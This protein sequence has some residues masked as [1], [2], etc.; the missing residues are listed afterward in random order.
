MK[1]PPTADRSAGLMELAGVHRATRRVTGLAMGFSVVTGLLGLTA[2]LYM[3]QVYD[4]VLA[5]RSVET[6]VALSLVMAFLFLILGILD[7]ARSRIMARV[8][9]RLQAA[10]DARVLAA[11][12]RR[13]ALAP[14]DMPALAA[15][16]DLDALSRFWASPVLLAL[17]D[18][19]WTPVFLVLIMLFHPLLGLLALAGGVILVLMAWAC[20]ST[21]T[22]PLKA[23][24][25][26]LLAADRQ[27]DTL[28]AE[29]EVVRAMGMGPAAIARWSAHRSR[30][31]ED[32]LAASDAAGTYA[33]ASRTFRLF[34]QSA[35]LGLAAWLV[36]QSELSAGAMLAVSVLMGRALQPIEQI[37][38][39]W[40][41]IARARLA[42]DRLA[43]LLTM[44]P[45]EVPRTPLP[46]PRAHLEVQGLSVTPPEA[47]SPVLRGVRFTL[48][49]GQAL[50]VIGPSGAG[51]STLARALTGLWQGCSGVIRLDGARLD[52][53]GAEGLGSLVGYLP[54]RVTLFEGTVADNIARLQTDA[55]PARIIAAA[56]AA[57]AHDM[58]L[59]LPQG[60][61][62]PVAALGN[63]LSGG[64]IQRIGL[65][66]A[67]FGD[68]VLLILDEPNAH[69]DTDGAEALNQAIRAAKAAG[70]AVLIM[71]HRPAA[72]QECDLLM[73]LR[74]GAVTAVGPRDTV[75]RDALRNAGDVSRAITPGAVA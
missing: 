16:R 21:T 12:F 36:L 57:A 65:A 58:I 54:Q 67:L 23:A 26:A 24:N 49:P 27:A 71:A 63:R 15:Q 72:I 14:L 18:A 38:A 25:Q 44:A 7:H 2:P 55:D 6:L 8:G 53:F 47:A 10:L 35:T 1:L 48:Q 32:G 74:D 75:L 11:A 22:L 73:V 68:P 45:V 17:F 31:L 28:K 51:K 29:A 61:D 20:Q 56:R 43:D 60:Y 66:R 69:L 50:G 59:R 4:R 39:Q 62:T 30:A 3:L 46:R 33:T 13:L 52:Q 9:A 40:P 34:L 37:V 42:R 41:V 5:A 64:Q 70:S 19:P